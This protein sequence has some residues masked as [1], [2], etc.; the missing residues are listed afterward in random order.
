MKY[1]ESTKNSVHTVHFK[2]VQMIG[3]LDN[4]EIDKSY[5]IHVLEML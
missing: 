2:N 3:Y 1:Y 5:K 4:G